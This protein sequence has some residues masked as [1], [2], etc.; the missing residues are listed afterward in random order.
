[1]HG[2]PVSIWEQL[3]S[4]IDFNLLKTIVQELAINVAIFYAPIKGAGLYRLRKDYKVKDLS[5]VIISPT[6][7]RKYTNIE[8]EEM[9]SQKIKKSIEEFAKVL[10]EN[11]PEDSL[12][13]LYNNINELVLRRNPLILFELCNGCYDTRKNKISFI[14]SSVL[15]HELFH[16]ASSIPKYHIVGFRNNGVGTGLNEGYTEV[17]TNRY[18]KV[19][20]KLFPVYVFERETMKNLEMIIGKEKMESLYL[21]ADLKGLI[22]EMQKYRTIEE[23]TKF[24]SNLDYISQHAEFTLG[25]KSKYIETPAREVQ[26]FLINAYTTKVKQQ[27][28]RNELQEIDFNKQILDYISLVG[29]NCKISGVKYSS[30]M[31]DSLLNRNNFNSLENTGTFKMA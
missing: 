9:A 31:T 5:K 29:E 2:V 14:T 13:N 24:I 11:F 22:T 26:D 18:F 4:R 28:E 10:I 1:M 6:L 27:V 8:I 19:K 25:V 23:I 12:T 7:N 20:K 16:M 21:K 17:L 3:L 15:N 30:L